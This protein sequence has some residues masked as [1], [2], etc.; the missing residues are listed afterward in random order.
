MAWLPREQHA[1]GGHVQFVP[2]PLS[3]AA[4]LRCVL[5]WRQLCG[6]A[7]TQQS[8]VGRPAFKLLKMLRYC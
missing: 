6:E 8:M 7:A 2:A 1:T 3:R 4:V 5:E